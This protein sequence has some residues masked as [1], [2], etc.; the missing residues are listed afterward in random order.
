M[1]RWLTSSW[2]WSRAAIAVT[3]PRWA[4]AWTRRLAAMP[5]LPLPRSQRCLLLPSLLESTAGAGSCCSGWGWRHAARGCCMVSGHGSILP[6]HS[7]FDDDVAF[8]GGTPALMSSRSVMTHIWVFPVLVTLRFP[9]FLIKFLKVSNILHVPSLS[10]PLLYVNRFTR[11][12][13]V[14]F[15]I[16]SD[17]FCC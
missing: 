11:D 13:N 17:L 7:R 12:N 4:R 8:R 5:N 14:F 2:W 15:L 3:R 1:I 9:L 10:V 6:R 16:S